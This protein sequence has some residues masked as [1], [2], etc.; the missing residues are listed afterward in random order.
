MFPPGFI[1]GKMEK[2]YQ[3]VRVVGTKS[4]YSERGQNQ[5]Q[6][7]VTC[8][9]RLGVYICVPFCSVHPARPGDPVIAIAVGS[10]SPGM[11]Q[12]AGVALYGHRFT[13][14]HSSALLKCDQ[15]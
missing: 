13:L 14:E 2:W 1:E 4:A 9:H 12:R 6:N 5:E 10:Y 7:I 11:T 8:R 3:H 15:R